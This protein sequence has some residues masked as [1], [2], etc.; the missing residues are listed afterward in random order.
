MF[1]GPEN[2]NTKCEVAQRSYFGKTAIEM[3]CLLGRTKMLQLF[4]N[5]EINLDGLNESGKLENIFILGVN[6][7]F[8]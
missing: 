1:D 2:L 5:N 4:A 7:K 3:A 6:F 8:Y